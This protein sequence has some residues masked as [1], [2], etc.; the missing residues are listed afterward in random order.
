MRAVGSPWG[1]VG[2]A[3]IAAF[4]VFMVTALGSIGNA[5]RDG[6]VRMPGKKVVTLAA[7]EY[8]VYYE[9]R[10]NTSSNETFKAPEGIRLRVRKLDDT[11][12]AKLDFGGLSNQVGTDNFTA[13]S[14]ASLEIAKRGRYR[15]I[16]GRPPEP[17]V[18]PSLTVGESASKSFVEGVKRAGIILGAAGLLAGL[19]ALTRRR[20]TAMAEPWV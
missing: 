14:I 12:D 10:V 4:A 17:A 7:G 1:I 18:K 6:R 20:G 13:E 2:L 15:L 9:E 11:P 19:L 16:A 5:D 3:G 8:S